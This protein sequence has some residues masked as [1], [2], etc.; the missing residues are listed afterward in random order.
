MKKAI[1]CLLCLALL[2]SLFACGKKTEEPV[3]PEEEPE[4]VQVPEEEPA[5]AIDEAE[6][7]P[8]EEEP[9]KEPEPGTLEYWEKLYPDAEIMEFEIEGEN[10]NALCFSALNSGIFHMADW[11][12]SDFNLT[13][14]HFYDDSHT[15]IVDETEAFR[16]TAED[17]FAPL[18]D[19][20]TVHTEP[21]V[22]EDA[23]PDG[24]ETADGEDTY[25]A[26]HMVNSYTDLGLHGIKLRG[27]LSEETYE[28]FAAH[29]YSLTRVAWQYTEGEWLSVY[30]D[31]DMDLNASANSERVH[32]LAVPH[33]SFGEY[34]SIDYWTLCGEAWTSGFA[35]DVMDISEEEY[36]KDCVGYAHWTGD[37]GEYD[38]LL[39]CDHDIVGWATVLVK[40]YTY[41]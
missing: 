24:E 6:A 29:P 22:P 37:P 5:A 11:I 20:C 33:R 18:A 26:F 39:L 10:E 2:V 4:P 7:E 16:I 13:G 12:G 3:Q 23:V 1:L 8:D 17:T 25:G 28:T 15:V 31:C 38:V 21:F 30:L 41:G 40:E 36:S 14:W 35:L 19:S 9:E 27:D 34:K 32:V